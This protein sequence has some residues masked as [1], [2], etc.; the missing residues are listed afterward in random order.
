MENGLRLVNDLESDLDQILVSSRNN[1]S[2]NGNV[3][4]IKEEHD[5]LY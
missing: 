1:N 3:Y 5:E 2:T 4:L